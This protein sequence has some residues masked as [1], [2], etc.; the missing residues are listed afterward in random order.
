MKRLKARWTYEE[1]QDIGQLFEDL[2]KS[3]EFQEY[4]DRLA[5]EAIIYQM[6][7]MDYK[8]IKN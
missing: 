4:L 1:D 8:V 3:K 7:L 5:D 6:E 2:R